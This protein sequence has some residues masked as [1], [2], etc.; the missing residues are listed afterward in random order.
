MS[1]FDDTLVEESVFVD[2]GDHDLF[3]HYAEKDMITE[4]LVMGTE[5]VALCGKIWVPSRDPS[6]Y[7]ICP[8]CKEIMDKIT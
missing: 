8:T 3:A 6:K 1:S 2:Q 7:P 5:V 4:A